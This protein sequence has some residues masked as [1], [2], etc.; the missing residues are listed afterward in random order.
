L[1][2]DTIIKRHVDSPMKEAKLLDGDQILFHATGSGET[3]DPTALAV[4]SI[5]NNQIRDIVHNQPILSSSLSPDGTRL[6]YSSVQGGK[7]II[8]VWYDLVNDK[9]IDIWDGYSYW[10]TLLN[11]NRYIDLSG[12]GYKSE[13]RMYD[14]KTGPK[15][16]KTIAMIN[17]SIYAKYAQSIDKSIEYQKKM[18]AKT[19]KPMLSPGGH[20]LSI[21]LMMT[22]GLSAIHTI[23]LDDDTASDTVEMEIYEFTTLRDGRLLISGRIDGVEGLYLASGGDAPVLLK[24]GMFSNL[25]A[26]SQM[27]A[28]S[29]LT[30]TGDERPKLLAGKLDGNRLTSEI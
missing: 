20:Y 14:L 12:Y 13:I 18:A 21:Q 26:S 1:R 28:V 29:Y 3:N 7:D 2:I 23:K 8:T 22:S 6:I 16:Y 24:E 25:A 17:D 5:D 15:K 11:D 4:Y 19:L 9:T 27:D 30:R 10:A